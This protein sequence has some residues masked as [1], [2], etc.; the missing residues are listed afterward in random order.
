MNETF[1]FLPLFF[2]IVWDGMI[3]LRICGEVVEVA[4]SN[5]M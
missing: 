2:A 1:V 3:V 5:D 4:G